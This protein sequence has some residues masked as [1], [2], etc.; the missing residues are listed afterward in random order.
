[1]GKESEL[2]SMAK[3]VVAGDVKAVE[4]GF[5]AMVSPSAAEV[6]TAPT[7][8]SKESEEVVPADAAV[9][10]AEKAAAGLRPEADDLLDDVMQEL[11]HALRKETGL[12]SGE[13]ATA[14]VHA[15]S[16]WVMVGHGGSW[17]VMVGHPGRLFSPEVKAFSDKP[18]CRR[19]F[20][21]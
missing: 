19:W 10:V 3:V 9:R 7:R 2:E 14:L 21:G 5:P 13:Y 4:T 15:R 6:A 16:W 8:K 11:S 12:I 20:G 1:M 18:R 17:W